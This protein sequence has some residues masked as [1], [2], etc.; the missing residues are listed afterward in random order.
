MLWNR[1]N[2]TPSERVYQTYELAT[3]AMQETEE[4]L[5][6]LV[7]QI[8]C[9]QKQRLA[10]QCSLSVFQN[11]VQLELRNMPRSG[12]C[13]SVA[14]LNVKSGNSEQAISTDIRRVEEILLHKLRAGDSFTRMNKGT[15][16]IMLPGASE[17]NAPI[18]ME[19]IRT[20]FIKIY[21]QTTAVLSYKIY[22]LQ[23]L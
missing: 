10:F 19:R 1:L 4:S 8:I 23:S 22:P 14:V 9:P 15:F 2:L 3:H 6:L 13:T 21:H 5:E 16:M 11:M 7:Q 12:H 17:E 20:E 18:A